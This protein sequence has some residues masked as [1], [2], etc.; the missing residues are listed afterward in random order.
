[1]PL[2]TSKA[3]SRFQTDFLARIRRT[4]GG[5]SVILGR[6]FAVQV[7]QRYAPLQRRPPQPFGMA[8][9]AQGVLIARNPNALAWRPRK[10]HNRAHGLRSF[11]AGR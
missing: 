2:S 11:Y 5:S 7:V 6:I 4:A 9:R 8:Q 10:I 3:R 1:M